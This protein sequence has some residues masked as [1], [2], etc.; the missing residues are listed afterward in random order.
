MNEYYSVL[1]FYNI[2]GNNIVGAL[3]SPQKKR[4]EK[5][6]IKYMI[7][8][9]FFECASRYMRFITIYQTAENKQENTEG[10]H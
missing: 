9:M 5:H 10:D 8:C 1:T 2:S 4:I 7:I 3:S 6:I